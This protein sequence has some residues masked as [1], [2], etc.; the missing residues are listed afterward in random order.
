MLRPIVAVPCLALALAASSTPAFAQ[1]T[2]VASLEQQRA[3][4]AKQV[5]P[6]R[7]GRIEKLLLYI[8]RED[9]LGKLSPHDGFFVRY[10]YTGKPLGAGTGLSAG[11]RHD[12]FGRR[13]RVL[14]EAG[15]SIR[16][17]R[18][19]RGDFSLPYLARDRF[20][21][22]LEASYRHDPQEDFYGPGSD[23]LESNRVSF[24]YNR[25]ELQ[26][27]AIFR[28]LRAVQLGTRFG[29]VNPEVGAGRDSRF[30]SIEQRFGDAD[31]PGLAA[32]PDFAHVGLFGIIDHRDEPG[33]PRDGGY[34][35]LVWRR[36]SDLDLDRHNF[37]GFS[38]DL[39]RFIPIF[40][41]KRVFALR[42][43]VVTTSPEAGQTVPFYMQPTLG[44]NDSVR[45]VADF[46]FRDNN[47]LAINVEYRWEATSWLDMALFT[48][49]G[50]TAA[51]AGDLDLSD[52][53]RAYG[54]GF[55]INSSKTVF[56]RADIAIGGGEAPQFFLKFNKAF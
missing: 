26:G 37:Q 29:R 19:V 24:L 3:E 18:M 8:E 51:R 35:G 25:T 31:A 22:G 10:G 23:S 46:R 14:V 28:P 45:S 55:R 9:P 34:Y 36:Y 1:D 16:K 49:W 43:R 39:Q 20:E 21:V 4:K 50:K 5:Q 32:Q 13:A 54:I 42:G 7:P 6:Y 15:A 30:P 52:L 47:A 17:Y 38:A 33:N 27:R 40:D 12:L 44:G 56:F 11:Y 2:R 48:D 41:K 53:E